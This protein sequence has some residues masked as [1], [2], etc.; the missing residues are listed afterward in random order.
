MLSEVV[1]KTIRASLPPLII[2]PESIPEKIPV[3]TDGTDWLTCRV[4]GVEAKVP[5]PERVMVP[6][7][8]T[9][10]PLGK[11]VLTVVV[12]WAAKA[13]V[14]PPLVVLVATTGVQPAPKQPVVLKVTTPACAAI[15]AS[16]KKA[17]AEIPNA[18]F[19]SI[20]EIRV[21]MLFISLRIVPCS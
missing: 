17:T 2:V 3:P 10:K 5:A 9:V 15:D 12:G 20:A 21:D 13:A 4:N 18:R 14:A 8:A 7:S 16:V 6:K 19:L 1:L 11:S